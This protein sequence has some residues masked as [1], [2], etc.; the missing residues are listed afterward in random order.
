MNEDLICKLEIMPK[1]KTPREK[2]HDEKL[3][4]LGSIEDVTRLSV[5]PDKSVE[6]RKDVISAM[7]RELGF[8]PSAPFHITSFEWIEQNIP[9]YSRAEIVAALGDMDGVK[10]LD[11]AAGSIALPPK[12][13]V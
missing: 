4:V 8:D 6:I 13:F 11:S 7:K 2:H 12:Y 10:V 3:S 9:G 1:A 5:T